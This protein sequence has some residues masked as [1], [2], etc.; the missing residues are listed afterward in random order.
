MDNPDVDAKRLKNCVPLALVREDDSQQ[1]VTGCRSSLVDRHERPQGS[2]GGTHS[3]RSA[4][5]MPVR[6]PSAASNIF[7]FDPS[8]FALYTEPPRSVRN[9]RPPLISSERPIAS[10]R[11][12]KTISGSLRLPRSASIG[13]RF[14]VLPRGGSP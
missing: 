2:G 6:F 13:A 4:Y 14:T 10:I 3:R 5:A 12:V 9:I 1:S 8:R 11:W 7:L